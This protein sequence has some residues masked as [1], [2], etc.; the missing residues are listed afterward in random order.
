LEAP[1]DTN[2]LGEQL[3]LTEDWGDREDLD[4]ENLLLGDLELLEGNLLGG[5]L[6]Q[7]LRGGFTLILRNLLKGFDEY[8]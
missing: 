4:G 8:P 7:V 1:L 6:D 3:R 5:V 2:L